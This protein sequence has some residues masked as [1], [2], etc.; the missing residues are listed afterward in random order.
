MMRFFL[1]S[2]FLLIA[3][4]GKVELNGPKLGQDVKYAPTIIGNSDPQY[5]G[6]KTICDAFG[7]KAAS[8]VGGATYSF[9]FSQKSCFNPS[10]PVN[11]QPAAT[12]E[13]LSTTIDLRAQAS[14]SVY[15][16]RR[17]DGRSFFDVETSTTGVLGSL[18]SSLSELKTQIK[19]A[20]N[21]LITFSTTAISGVECSP[22]SNQKCIKISYHAPVPGSENTYRNHTIEFLKFNVN[23][24]L[25]R[26]GFWVERKRISKADC[27]LNEETNQLAT[28]R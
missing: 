21:Q 15:Y 26:S 17:S 28:L 6:L 8:L 25:T 12:T 19:T 11:E 2:I 24:Q 1:G 13:T 20:D 5:Q 14:G 18:C 7:A 3:S 10:L 16:F 4:C 23:S 9:D 27:A 22:G